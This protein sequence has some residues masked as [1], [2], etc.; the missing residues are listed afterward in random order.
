MFRSKLTALLTRPFCVLLVFFCVCGT[1]AAQTGS[2]VPAQV[3]GQT[4]TTPG[5]RGST[6]DHSGSPAKPSNVSGEEVWSTFKPVIQFGLIAAIGGA[7]IWFMNL[8][9]VIHAWE[10]R[11]VVAIAIVLTYCFSVFI[12]DLGAA[13][14]GIKD[15]VLVVIGFYFGTKQTAASVEPPKS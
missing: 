13:S 14:S 15:V 7:F 8:P 6:S 5:A 4:T 1:A 2:P 3:N 12:P 11:T 9:S 10:E